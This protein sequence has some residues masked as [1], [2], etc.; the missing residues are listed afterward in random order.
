MAIH[1]ENKKL[2]L[3]KFGIETK[4]WINIIYTN[5]QDKYKYYI[6]QL[7]YHSIMS[8]TSFNIMFIKIKTLI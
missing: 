3:L 7:G 1:N 8:L 2:K 6:V 5:I 4:L